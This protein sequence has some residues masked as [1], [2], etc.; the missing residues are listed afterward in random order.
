MF[1]ANFCGELKI[2]TDKG[3][4]HSCVRD[5]ENQ[6]VKYIQPISNFFEMARLTNI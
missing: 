6:S 2:V 3:Q 4:N 5:S 1:S